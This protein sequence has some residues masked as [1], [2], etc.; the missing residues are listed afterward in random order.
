MS[1]SCFKKPVPLVK[2]IMLADV[3]IQSCPAKML[4]NFSLCSAFFRM[5]CS[6]DVVYKG[7]ES[8]DP[9]NIFADPFTVCLFSPP[10]LRWSG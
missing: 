4:G 2:G 10:P 7:L 8:Q 5:F 3:K 6:L 9:A 1:I